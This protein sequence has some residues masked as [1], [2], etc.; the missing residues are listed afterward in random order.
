M[1]SYQKK[2][3]SITHIVLTID[4]LVSEIKNNQNK[5][6]ISKLHKLEYKSKDYNKLKESLP[7]IRINGS[8]SGLKGS[9]VISFNNYFYFDIDGEVLDKDKLVK[10]YPF[11]SLITKSVGGRGIFF[12]VKIDNIELNKGDIGVR[13]SEHTKMWNYLRTEI[14]KDL[15]IDKN[16]YS[17]PRGC[18]IPYDENIYYNDISYSIDILK[19]TTYK[20]VNK[21]KVNR[22]GKRVDVNTLNEPIYKI[23]EL[24][25]LLKRINIRTQYNKEIKELYAI[26]EINSYCITIPKI[27]KDGMKHK[28][29]HRLINALV[30]INPNITLQEMISYIYHV[31]NH[32]IKKM[33]QRELI[34]YTTLI[35]NHIMETGEVKIKP[36]IKKIHFKMEN[37]NLSVRDKQ[38]ISAKVNGI[39]R[40]N[41]TIDKI[42]EA[43]NLIYSMNEVPTNQRLVEITGLSLSTIKRNKNKEKN[44]PMKLN[45]FKIKNNDIVKYT[46][47]D[48]D[49][50]FRKE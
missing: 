4:E 46:T 1:F 5:E 45:N 40:T 24:N 44:D 9:D 21:F 25:E 22:G 6:I 28:L 3:T 29:Y 16:A 32:A 11:I 2:I 36:R 50:F 15:N 34:R 47:I 12:L 23:I 20:E 43:I 8:F 18:F 26:E 42:Q 17:I 37:K 41:N 35:Y 49:D 10:K 13:I 7:L 27:I 30:Y 19:Y 31:N 33:I 48:E 38:V 39:L 14:F